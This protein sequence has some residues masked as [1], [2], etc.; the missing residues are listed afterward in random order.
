M[1]RPKHL[2]DKGSG[3][4]VAGRATEGEDKT[5]YR[6]VNVRLGRQDPEFR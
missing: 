1:G 6:A 3:L 5:I 2:K 4:N